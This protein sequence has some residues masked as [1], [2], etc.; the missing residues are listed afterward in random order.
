MELGGVRDLNLHKN[1]LLHVIKKFNLK[2]N[3]KQAVG[4]V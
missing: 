3:Y 4:R 2:I 1:N